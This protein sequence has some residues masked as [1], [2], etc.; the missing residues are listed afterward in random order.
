MGT[1][2]LAGIFV[3]GYY[4][5][6]RQPSLKGSQPLPASSTASGQ[7]APAQTGES[8]D[9]KEGSVVGRSK[10]IGKA[11]ERPASHPDACTEAAAALDLCP[12]SPIQQQEAEATAAVRPAIPRTQS[13]NA[14]KADG[15]ESL[16][17]ECS[18]AVSALGLCTP[19][20]TR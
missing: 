3:L 13:A 7:S 19:N 18:E 2:V 6:S 16:R 15:Q 4:H 14:V 17:S 10:A 12:T 9:G 8:Q 11:G 1:A 5:Y 20:P